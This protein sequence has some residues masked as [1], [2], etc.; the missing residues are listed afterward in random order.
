MSTGLR[1]WNINL[2][3]TILEI[4]HCPVFYLKHSFS[5][6]E[7]CLGLSLEIGTSSPDWDQLSRFNLKTGQNPVSNKCCRNYFR[8]GLWWRLM[9]SMIMIVIY[10]CVYCVLI[11]IWARCKTTLSSIRFINVTTVRNYFSF[12]LFSFFTTCFGLYRGHL[13]VCIDVVKKLNKA[14][15]K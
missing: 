4:I 6:T 3:I 13:Q 14:N 15:E 11:I 1:Q 10:K 9:M 12:A 8:R 7:F 5:K 2:T